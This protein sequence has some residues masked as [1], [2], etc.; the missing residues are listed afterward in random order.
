MA[1]YGL[2]KKYHPDVNKDPSAKHK[3]ADAQSAYEI[4]IDP[5][6]KKAWCRNNRYESSVT[7]K[8]KA[9]EAPKKKASEAPKK[10]ASEA[11]KK[12][13][14]EAPKKEASEA[15]KKEASEAPKE[16]EDDDDIFGLSKE[17]LRRWEEIVRRREEAIR[18]REEAIRGGSV[19]PRPLD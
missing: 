5:E 11:P 9:S 1:Y 10:R 7:P 6:K 14:S 3:F 2:A 8:E 4:L 15:P 19:P 12:T 18:R 13:T 16:E 17:T